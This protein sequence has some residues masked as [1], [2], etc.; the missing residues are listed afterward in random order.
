MMLNTSTILINPEAFTSLL[1]GPITPRPAGLILM[2]V[3]LTI[4][5]IF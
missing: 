5:A 1:E 4:S 2:I 3:D